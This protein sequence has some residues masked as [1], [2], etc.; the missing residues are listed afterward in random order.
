MI[1]ETKWFNGLF[2]V[3]YGESPRPVGAPQ[4]S[5][6]PK[7]VED[8]RERVPNIVKREGL[9]GQGASAGHGENGGGSAPPQ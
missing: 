4:A 9:A 1:R 8:P 7:R 3:D 5:L 2:V 6:E